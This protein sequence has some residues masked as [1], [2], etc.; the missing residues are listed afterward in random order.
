MSAFTPLGEFEL[1]GIRCEW[2]VRHYAGAS[3]AYENHRGLSACVRVAGKQSKE[4]IVD[5]DIGDYF[6]RKKPPSTVAFQSRLQECVRAALASGWKPESRGKP[7]RVNA[8]ELAAQSGVV[9]T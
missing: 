3:N 9:A 5:F 6:F 1:D 7:F 8:T 4:L 2:F